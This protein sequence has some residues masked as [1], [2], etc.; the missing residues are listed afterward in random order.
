MINSAS[1]CSLPIHTSGCNQKD[2][3]SNR[4]KE[5]QDFILSTCYVYDENK[6]LSTSMIT[7]DPSKKFDTVDSDDTLPLDDIMVDDEVQLLCNR[8]TDI[9]LS[10]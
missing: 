10:V 3:S 4:G 8:T 2:D 6:A 7:H 1:Q 5:M 9:K